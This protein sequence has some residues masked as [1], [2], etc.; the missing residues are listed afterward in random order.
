MLLISHVEIISI[1][2]SRIAKLELLIVTMGLGH[3]KTDIITRL[4]MTND[5]AR[6]RYAFILMALYFLQVGGDEHLGFGGERENG[7]ALFGV[8]AKPIRVGHLET[9][10]P[11]GAFFHISDVF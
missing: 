6:S 9:M 8:S 11:T 3:F 2:P 4:S 5:H 1:Y 7:V 10:Q